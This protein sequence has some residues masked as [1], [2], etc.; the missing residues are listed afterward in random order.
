DSMVSK[1]IMLMV[2]LAAFLPAPSAARGEEVTAGL[3]EVNGT[4]LYYEVSGQGHPLVFIH[5]G[6]LSSTEWN[7]Q[8]HPFAE[9]YRTIRY[10]VRGFGKSETRKLPYS[11]T[12]DLSDLL[13]F[14]RVEKTY[15][16]GGSMGGAIAVDFALEHPA[17]VDALILVGPSVGGWQYS[18][19]FGQRIY[20]IMLATVAEGAEK[21]ADLWLGV[22]YLIPAPDNPAAREQFRRLFTADFHGFLAPWYL[23]RPLNPPTL[24]RLSQLHVPTLIIMGQLEDPENLAVADTL[25]TKIAGAKKIVV[26]NAGHLV[27][28][29]K[30]EEFNRIVL[31]FLSGR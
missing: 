28:M 16:V 24:Q 11:N 23:A 15:L 22:P 5:G 3:T 7:E 20:Q 10:D 21:G 19:E 14:L 29:E 4:K 18:P 13:R 25:A 1:R 27:D 8:F 6:L 9:H 17:M 30:P 2:A 26:P 31:D 12:E